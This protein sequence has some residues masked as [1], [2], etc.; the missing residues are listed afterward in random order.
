MYLQRNTI[1][2]N[3]VSSL[4]DMPSCGLRAQSDLRK[5]S[6]LVI[7]MEPLGFVLTT[8]VDDL[9]LRLQ[10][11]ATILCSFNVH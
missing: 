11:R 7:T 10:Q 8:Q 9:L 2:N 3:K 5:V 1:N 6:G 4:A